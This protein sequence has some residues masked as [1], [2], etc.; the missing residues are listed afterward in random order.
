MRHSHRLC[1]RSRSCAWRS[2]FSNNIRF[3]WR[4][5][6]A[7]CEVSNSII[8]QSP[9]VSFKYFNFEVVQ[10]N[11][12]NSKLLIERE[13]ERAKRTTEIPAIRRSNSKVSRAWIPFCTRIVAINCIAFAWKLNTK[14]TCR[15]RLCVGVTNS[16]L[17]FNSPSTQR[18]TLESRCRR[19]LRC[20]LIRL[21]TPNW[22]YDFVPVD[23]DFSS[24]FRSL[25]LRFT[26]FKWNAKCQRQSDP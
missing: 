20:H 18:N 13:R 6:S 17:F 23:T 5:S 14:T 7:I 21:S 10:I 4:A 16:I 24:C 22:I 9:F 19:A 15:R 11:Q 25:Q 8:H 12:F 1:V 3:Y 26:R 2:L